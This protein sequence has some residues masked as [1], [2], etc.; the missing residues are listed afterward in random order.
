MW[1]T[2]TV[3]TVAVVR[4]LPDFAVGAPLD[5]D[6]KVYIYHGS[7]SG[8]VTKPAQVSLPY[9]HL[10]V[11]G[12]GLG[13]TAFLWPSSPFSLGCASFLCSHPKSRSNLS[14]PCFAPI[15]LCRF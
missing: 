12:S 14:L 9:P 15:I 3:L 11:K 13:N 10:A 8:F 2:K 6:G 1:E 7:N 4:F 5:G